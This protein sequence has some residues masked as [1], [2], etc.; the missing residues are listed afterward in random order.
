MRSRSAVLPRFL[1][2]LLLPLL[3]KGDNGFPSLPTGF[4]HDLDDVSVSAG[5]FHT[6]AIEARPGQDFG[7]T[8]KCWGDDAH[9]QASPP[10]GTFVQV[11]AG[12]YH[13]CAVG[14]DEQVSACDANSGRGNVLFAD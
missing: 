6:C 9:G 14:I 2:P 1:V 5:Y 3:A 7:G 10:E 12:F 4:H 8:L 11:S 13:T